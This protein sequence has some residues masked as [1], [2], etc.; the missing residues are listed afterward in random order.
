MDGWHAQVLTH[1][2]RG[3]DVAV[4]TCRTG[5]P[6]PFH[7]GQHVTIECP[8]RPWQSRAYAMA[9]AP[10]PDRVLEFHV[11]AAGVAGVSAALVRR[12]KPGDMLRLSEPRGTLALDSFSRRDAVF[13]A[14]GTGL[15]PAKALIEEL[16]RFN[17]TRWIHLFRGER[18]LS[19]FYDRPSLDR[20]E[21]QHPWLTVLRATS[22]E[23][24]EDGEQATVADLIAR[25]GPWPDHDF[26]VFGSSGMVSETLIRLDDLGVTPDR[27]RHGTYDITPA[28]R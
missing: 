15:A 27:I 3:P 20:M 12:L 5:V 19:D 4:F 7:A 6:L 8:Y 13:V 24:G 25:H 21:R 1:E 22:D 2:R 9:N 28:A 10:R 16:A 18:R 26:Y 23:P 11:R 17:R 14:G